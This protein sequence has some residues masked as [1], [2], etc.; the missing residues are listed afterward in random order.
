MPCQEDLR[1]QCDS[2]KNDI[3]AKALSNHVEKHPLILT[4]EASSYYR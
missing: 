4:S 2:W 3:V 1:L